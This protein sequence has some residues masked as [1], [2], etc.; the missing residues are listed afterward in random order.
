MRRRV[1]FET[2]S[3]ATYDPGLSLVEVEPRHELP[4]KVTVAEV[5]GFRDVLDS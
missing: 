4:R 1:R 3:R 5:E 2:L